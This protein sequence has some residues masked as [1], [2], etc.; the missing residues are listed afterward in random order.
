MDKYYTTLQYQEYVDDLYNSCR[1][2]DDNRVFAKSCK[3]GWSKNVLNK[4]PIYDKFYVRIGEDKKLYNPF[5]LYSVSDNRGSFLDRVCRSNSNYKP[6]TQSVFNM[7]LNFLKTENMQ[8]YNQAQREL[9]N[10]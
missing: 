3:L 2:K 9:K 4:E 7:Y 8:W 10:L 6:V 1:S 5:P